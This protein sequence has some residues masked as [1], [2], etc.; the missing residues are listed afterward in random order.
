MIN[1]IYQDRLGY[2]WIGTINGLVRYDGYEFDL[3]TPDPGNYFA[4]NIN[5]VTAIYE[6][7][8]ENLWIGYV[9]GVS[10]FNRIDETFTFFDLRSHAPGDDREL[11]VLDF[12]EDKN[13]RMWVACSEYYFRAIPNGL[14]YIDDT[15][16]VIKQFKQNSDIE[17]SNVNDFIVDDNNDIWFGSYSGLYQ[18]L[19]GGEKIQRY[20]PPSATESASVVQMQKGDQNTLWLTTFN[21][22]LFRFKTDNKSFKKYLVKPPGLRVNEVVHLFS[23]TR[24]MAGFL[25]LWSSHGLWTFDPITEKFRLIPTNGNQHSSL[26]SENL[27]QI[28]TDR[29]GSIWLTTQDNGI[30]KYDPGKTI[31]RSYKQEQINPH[32]RQ[33]G[34]VD[35]IFED[36]QENLW[37]SFNALYK[38]DRE[39]NSFS[40]IPLEYRTGITTLYQ[41]KKKKLWIGGTY[42]LYYLDKKSQSIKLL[43]LP[44]PQSDLYIHSLYEDISGKLWLGTGNGIYILNQNKTDYHHIEFDAEN[45]A[46]VAANQISYLIG[47]DGTDI[48]WVGTN[49]GL[50]K[51]D[52]KTYEY[53]KVGSD[54]PE[55]NDLISQDINSIYQDNSGIIWLGTWLGGLT[56]FDPVN[57]TFENYTTENGLASSAVQGILGDEENNAL[58]LS[59]FDGISRFDLLTKKFK[60]YDVSDG[61]Q[62]NQFA[63]GAYF[64]TRRGEFVF[65]GANGFT[66]FTADEIKKDLDSPEVILSDFK[67]FNKTIIPDKNAPLS[68]PIYEAEEIILDHDENDISFDFLAMF[69]INPTKNKYAYMLE[70]FEENW[71]YVGS[72]RTAVYPNLPPP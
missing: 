59:T 53:Q 19:A 45:I 41:D 72:Q 43:D 31:F 17:I 3:Y 38:F 26:Q 51:L 65:G 40:S 42:G 25:W 21:Q 55:V 36:S 44:I 8:K 34:W 69:F 16:N 27:S 18:I 68:K 46:R 1:T 61:I 49:S 6:D 2:I 10:K 7:S 57:N 23:L 13:G 35:I 64:K 14:F 47:E 5:V 50:F 71:R 54:N 37:L 24:D 20:N 62:G 11:R 56:R 60:N 12:C 66:I 4:A 28:M 39:S 63:D 52:T 58:W 67:L 32:G 33:F 29:N 30:Y 15:S 70:N 22:G 9:R 48:V